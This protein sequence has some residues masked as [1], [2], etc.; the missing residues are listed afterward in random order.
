MW[1]EMQD[2]KVALEADTAECLVVC[3]EGDFAEQKRVID[4][5]I[6]GGEKPTLHSILTTMKAAME[7]KD[8]D[9]MRACETLVRTYRD[10]YS[11]QAKQK[12]R[13]EPEMR[14]EVKLHMQGMMEKLGVQL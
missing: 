2:K 1:G 9:Y 10:L 13:N 5:L 4:Y 11:V 7:H 3:F 8:S 14:K 6:S 12:L